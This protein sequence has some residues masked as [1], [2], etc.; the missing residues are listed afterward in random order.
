MTNTKVKGHLD[1]FRATCWKLITAYFSFSYP[2]DCGCGYKK[3]KYRFYLVDIIRTIGV[4][5]KQYGYQ[6]YT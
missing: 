2:S 4:D 3:A 6:L 5:D 1:C